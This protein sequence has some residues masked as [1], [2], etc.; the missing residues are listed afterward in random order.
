MLRRDPLSP[1]SV[2]IDQLDSPKKIKSG[3]SESASYT[4][5]AQKK[6]YGMPVDLVAKN[7]STL[8]MVW[9]PGTFGYSPLQLREF[10]QEQ[11]PLMDLDKIKF[12]TK[13]HGKQGGDNFGEGSLDIR[14]IASFGLGVSTLVSN[15][16]TSS[17]TE[18]G[19][20][21]GQALLDFLTSLAQRETIPNVLSMSLG[22]IYIYKKNTCKI[23]MYI[24][25]IYKMCMCV[26]RLPR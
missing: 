2:A 21:F 1:D 4:I 6:A 26:C 9:G 5:A 20:G 24:Y 10:K 11:C 13:N 16:N 8:Q 12:D 14:M 3:A 18:E 7:E 19:S 25:E 17:S 22:Y 23:C 15:T